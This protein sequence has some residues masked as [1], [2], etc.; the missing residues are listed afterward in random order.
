MKAVQ[1]LGEKKPNNCT[2]QAFY[3]IVAPFFNE[4][5]HKHVNNNKKRR[6]FN[7]TASLKT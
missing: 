6:R 3:A 5:L 4:Q 7:D 2:K 1:L